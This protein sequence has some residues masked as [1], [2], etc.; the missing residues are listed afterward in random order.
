[1]VRLH[2]VVPEPLSGKGQIG[3]DVWQADVTFQKGRIYNVYAPSGK[4]K[5]TFVHIVYGIRKDF[6]G[7]VDIEN[8]PFISRKEND[9]A[10]LRQHKISIVFQDLRLFPAL[11]ALENIRIKT[12]LLPAES[13]PSIEEFASE[14]GVEPLLKRPT[15]T[16]SYGERQR[17]AIIRA[18][19]QP[20]DMLLLDEPFSHLDT[21]NIDKAVNLIARESKRRNAGVIVTSL[22]PA[23]EFSYDNVFK[24]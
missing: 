18:L 24:L 5:S 16:L 2:D 15:F 14:L 22:N 12:E 20:F 8:V 21:K 9:W 17:M 10:E 19:M 23:S 7:Q 11:S 6:T 4:G 13:H 3:S 1:M